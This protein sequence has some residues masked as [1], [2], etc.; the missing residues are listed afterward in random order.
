MLLCYAMPIW[1]GEMVTAYRVSDAERSRRAERLR[2]LHTDP[3]FKKKQ[4]A[5][6]RL[7]R[8]RRP[9]G[10]YWKKRTASRLLEP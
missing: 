7:W 9:Y 2:R 4:R 1:P 3:E 10:D 8:K 5:A 6:I